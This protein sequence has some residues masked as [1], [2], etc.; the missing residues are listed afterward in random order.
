MSAEGEELV[1]TSSCG[2][3]LVG[4]VNLCCRVE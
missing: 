4:F 1:W 3:F 2:K